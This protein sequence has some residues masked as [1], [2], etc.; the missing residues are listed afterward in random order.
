MWYC[1]I[2]TLVEDVASNIPIPENQT[3]LV[4]PLTS[5]AIAVMR[6]NPADFT[7]QTFSANFGNDFTFDDTKVIN[8]DLLAFEE[9]TSATAS[10]SI[11]PNVLDLIAAISKGNASITRRLTFGLFLGDVLFSSR[12]ASK[13]EVGSIIMSASLTDSEKVKNLSPPIIVTFQ[14]SPLVLNGTEASCN[15]WDLSADGQ[16]L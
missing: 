9:T 5:Y 10:L 3:S 12:N 1:R 8:P 4:I 2:L 7:G 11:P 14:K 13:L 6:V 15:F 16:A